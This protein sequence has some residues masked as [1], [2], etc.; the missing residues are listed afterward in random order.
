MRKRS[1]RQNATRSRVWSRGMNP[2]RSLSQAQRRRRD[3]PEEKTHRIMLMRS[4]KRIEAMRKTMSQVSQVHLA[5]V[6]AKMDFWLKPKRASPISLSKNRTLSK[7]SVSAFRAMSTTLRSVL[8]WPNAAH[9]CSK[10]SLWSNVSLFSLSRFWSH[11]S[12]CM[13]MDF[14]AS[15]HLRWILWPSESSAHCSFTWSS[16]QR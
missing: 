6:R 13:S 11:S 15:S 14:A 3:K 5:L 4:T 12:S 1:R 16:M 10:D 8:T 9:P 7:M 2:N